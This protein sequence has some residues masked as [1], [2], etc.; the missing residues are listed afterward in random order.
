MGCGGGVESILRTD[1]F[2]LLILLRLPF[3]CLIAAIS[4]SS[5]CAP[6]QVEVST[7]LEEW[8]L[9]VRDAIGA[10]RKQE[11]PK[12]R[13]QAQERSPPHF[14]PCFSHGRTSA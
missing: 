9:H 1:P 13:A 2:S 8:N 5:P 10:A 14:A 11:G 4:P 6:P 3:P 12:L 7:A